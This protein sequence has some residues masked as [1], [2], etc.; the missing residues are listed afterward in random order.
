MAKKS[1]KPKTDPWSEKQFDKSKVKGNEQLWKEAAEGLA[2][3]PSD[4]DKVK[5]IL[6]GHDPK[7]KKKT[8][9]EA[10]PRMGNNQTKG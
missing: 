3:P 2:P 5:T 9:S 7:R 6:L 8:Y 4:E 1:T 10:R